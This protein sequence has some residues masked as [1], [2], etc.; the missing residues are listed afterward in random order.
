MSYLDYLR[1]FPAAQREVANLPPYV[2]MN[3][4]MVMDLKDEPEL[5]DYQ[6]YL[7]QRVF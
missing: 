6:F 4:I 7:E 3:S 1:F 2:K 5:A